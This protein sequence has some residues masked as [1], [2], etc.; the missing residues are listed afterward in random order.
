MKI[1]EVTPR[2]PGVLHIVSDDGSSGVFDVRPYMDFD[3]F[4]P[5]KDWSEFSEV[6]N[7]GYFVEWRCGADLSAETIEARWERSGN[8]TF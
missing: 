7:G 4:R 8:T 5:L 1:V 6:R 2:K 3:A